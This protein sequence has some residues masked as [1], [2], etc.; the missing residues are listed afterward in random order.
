MPVP[1]CRAR[2]RA[3]FGVDGLEAGY[4]ESALAPVPALGVLGPMQIGPVAGRPETLTHAGVL[5]LLE[6]LAT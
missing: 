2:G 4:L 3:L 1:H 5:V 6:G